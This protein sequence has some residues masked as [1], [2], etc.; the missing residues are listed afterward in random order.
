MVNNLRPN[1]SIDVRSALNLIAQTGPGVVTIIGTAQWGPMNTVVE[2]DNFSEALNTFKDDSTTLDLTLTPALD[3]LYQNGA[4]SVKAIRINDGDAASSAVTLSA[5]ATSVITVYGKFLGTYGDNISVAITEDG[6][7]R[8]ATLSDG[9]ITEFYDN[10]GL[11]YTTNLDLVDDLNDQS[12]LIAATSLNNTF[13]VDAVTA[14]NLTGGDDGENALVTAD[15]TDAIDSHLTQNDA[16]ILVIPGQTADAFHTTI[17]GKLDTLSANENKHL[18]YL[19]GIGKDETI[20]TAQ[21][22]T[23]SGKRVVVA[24]PNVVKEHRISGTDEFLD[25]SYLACALAGK[26]AQIY[27]AGSATHKTLNIQG[28][29]VNE[30]SGKE[31]Y[32]KTEQ[33]TLLNANITPVTNIGGSLRAS[34]AVTRETD[35]TSVF[36]ELSIVTIENTLRNQV[37]DLLNGFI[38]EP[39][40]SRVRDVIAKNVDGI[41]ETNVNDEILTSYQPTQVT[42][43]ASPD[44]IN[45]QMTV[46]PVFALNFI[47][48]TV[49]F[50]SQ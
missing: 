23:A 16:D 41:L 12:D 46:L 3:L 22:R 11:T 13:L 42:V 21:G 37:L 40:L 49:N 5:G 25:G 33:N 47:S 27:P 24:A 36:Y 15:F 8:T 18:V 32:N 34:R 20:A 43:A 45:V 38:G 6:S 35:T 14:T 39:N 44:T 26:V 30:A 50:N 31:F 2:L 1:V 19:T 9:S 48:V 17:A 29:S 7:G 10:G 28:L 4:S